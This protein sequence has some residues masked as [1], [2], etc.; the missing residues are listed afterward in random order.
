MTWFIDLRAISK[1]GVCATEATLRRSDKTQAPLSELLSVIE[2]KHVLLGTHGF[3]VD[4]QE[5]IGSL[6]AWEHLLSLDEQTVFIGVLWAGDSRWLPV[7]DYPIEG[8]E[9]IASARLLAPFLDE[10]FN[11]ATG[12]SFVS[13]SLGARM[14]LETI[15]NLRREQVERLIL[16]AGAIDDNCLNREYKTAARKVR[17]ISLLAS[18]CD[19]VLQLAFPLGNPLAG[20]ISRGHPYWHSA[21]G[22]SGPDAPYVSNLRPG[23]LIPKAWNYGHGD[24]LCDEPYSLAQKQPPPVYAPIKNST[25]PTDNPA[26]SAGFVSTRLDPA[27]LRRALNNDG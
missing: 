15:S 1:G 23:W 20:I 16:M 19:R 4:R 18:P 17:E 24:Y 14:V 22:Y 3:N 9:A 2:G 12:L 7:L 11:R 6:T 27:L 5:G 26:R 25:V 21:L 10:H 13:H 8:E